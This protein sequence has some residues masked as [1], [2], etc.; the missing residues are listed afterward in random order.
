MAAPGVNIKLAP[1]WQVSPWL[2]VLGGANS[3]LTRR[4]MERPM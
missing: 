4:S 1:A 3:T 2:H